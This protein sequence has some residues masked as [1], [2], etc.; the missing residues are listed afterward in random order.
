[1]LFLL[2]D[3]NQKLL[4]PLDGAQ[5]LISTGFISKNVCFDL[6][7]LSSIRL[8]AGNIRFWYFEKAY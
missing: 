1:M 8:S 6:N 5:S 7:K 4:F 2:F 3:F